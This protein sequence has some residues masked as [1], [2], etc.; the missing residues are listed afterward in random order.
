MITVARPARRHRQSIGTDQD[1]SGTMLIIGVMAVLI[2]I[3]AAATLVSGYAVA[4][5]GA[6]NAAD[7]S[8][9]SGAHAMSAGADACAAAEEIARSNHVALAGCSVVGEAGDFVITVTVQ[10]DVGTR[11]PG[12]PTELTQRAWAGVVPAD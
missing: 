7:L 8:A 1:G 4:A 3:G 2:M 12:L 9:L 11:I 6:R 10:V 5:H